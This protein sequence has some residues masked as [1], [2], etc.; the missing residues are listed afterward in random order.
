VIKQKD[1]DRLANLTFRLNRVVLGHDEDG[2]ELSSLVS[3]HHDMGAQI[4]ANGMAK[5]AGHE[6]LVMH[7]LTQAGGQ[8]LDRDLRFAFYNR[9]GAEAVAGGKQYNQDTARK[10]YLRAYASLRDK[11]MVVLNASGIVTSCLEDETRAG[12]QAGHDRDMA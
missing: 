4:M 8:I 5:L 7:L 9:L 1:G 12:H 6:Q 11:G 10:A 2:E 3:E